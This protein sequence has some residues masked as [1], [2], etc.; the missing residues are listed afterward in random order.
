MAVAIETLRMEYDDLMKQYNA[1]EESW[2][3]HEKFV[4]LQER[5]FWGSAP[6]SIESAETADDCETMCAAEAQC[7]GAT[8]SPSAKLCHL[9][10]GQGK[11]TPANSPGDV[12]IVSSR[13]H[14]GQ[15]MRERQAR[16][17]DLNARIAGEMASAKAEEQ[18]GADVR[19]RQA[20]DLASLDAQLQALRDQDEAD[21]LVQLQEETQQSGLE[22]NYQ[23]THWL[24]WAVAAAIVAVVIAKTVLTGHAPAKGLVVLSVLLLAIWLYRTYLVAP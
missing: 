24:V 9:R 5:S 13:D 12:A 20:Q 4:V 11:V 2:K 1:A 21:S 22:V 3:E 18:A 7:T 8:F 6:V 10:S 19:D 14:A 23:R 16:I 15:L 17:T